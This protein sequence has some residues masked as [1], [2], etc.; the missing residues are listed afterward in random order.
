[1]DPE[2]ERVLAELD[3][4][5]RVRRAHL[6]SLLSASVPPPAT[7]SRIGYAIL[8]AED[9]G[10][11]GSLQVACQLLGLP[12]D[13]ESPTWQAAA[14]HSA[15]LRKEIERRTWAVLLAIA[16]AADEW[17]LDDIPPEEVRDD[18]V[19]QAYLQ[20]VAATGYTFS[21]VEAEQLLAPLDTPI[22]GPVCQVCGCT[23]DQACEGGCAWA[24]T[25]DG[26]PLCTACA[27]KGAA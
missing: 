23:D 7:W 10:H 9:F 15:A 3:V 14:V 16:I 27:E 13:I 21:P 18:H 4:A 20:W 5:A 11:H 8:E 26:S 25:D 1:V 17:I 2:Q 22:E 12:A 6:T 19:L 24:E